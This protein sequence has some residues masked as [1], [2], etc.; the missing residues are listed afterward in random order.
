MQQIRNGTT[1]AALTIKQGAAVTFCRMALAFALT[2]HGGHDGHCL[3]RLIDPF[4]VF[5]CY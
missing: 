3:Y 2:T 1:A 4:A 5:A